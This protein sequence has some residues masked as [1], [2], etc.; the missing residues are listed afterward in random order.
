MRLWTSMRDGKMQWRKGS[1]GAGH[2]CG[3]ADWL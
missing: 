1:E 3:E 2:L